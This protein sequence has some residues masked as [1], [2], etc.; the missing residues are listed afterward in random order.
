MAISLGDF[1]S[2]TADAIANYAVQQYC[3]TIEY[4]DYCE[5][6]EYLTYYKGECVGGL[7]EMAQVCL[8]SA[9]LCEE[10]WEYNAR[11][12][13]EWSNGNE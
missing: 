6:G 9:W 13:C 2:S 1:P 10:D 5:N 8:N 11:Y 12:A 7:K 3:E 4:C